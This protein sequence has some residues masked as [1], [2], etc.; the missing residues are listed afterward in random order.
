MY[1][2]SE[3]NA[4]ARKHV[5]D[6]YDDLARGVLSVAMET[7]NATS[8]ANILDKWEWRIKRIRKFVEEYI[9]QNTE[10]DLFHW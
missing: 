10:N 9:G 6:I 2:K 4:I 7:C 8:A 1:D 5:K 3:I